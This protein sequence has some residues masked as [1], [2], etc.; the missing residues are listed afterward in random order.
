[1]GRKTGV[2]IPEEKI[3]LVRQIAREEFTKNGYQGTST[4]IIIQRAQISKGSLFNLFGNKKN[5]YFELI[6]QSSGF[7]VNQ[8]EMKLKKMP[9]DYVERML[10]IGD[11]YLNM[12]IKEPELFSFLM[13][14][15]CWRE[16]KLS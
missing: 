15:I 14:L 2:A 8:L 10:W 11:L 13:T 9:R 6:R 4:N 7:F 16:R 1:M 5:L 3:E 12:F